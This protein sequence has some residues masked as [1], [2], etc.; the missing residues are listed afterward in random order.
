MPHIFSN[1]VTNFTPSVTKIGSFE[2][3]KSF[4]GRD[5]AIIY[6]VS[7]DD[8]DFTLL[9]RKKGNRF[10]LKYDKP[11]RPAST[12][13]LAKALQ[14]MHDLLGL[15]D[16]ETN[17]S[18]VHKPKNISNPKLLRPS[19]FLEN[20]RYLEDKNGELEIGFG[21]GRHLLAIAKE[22]P[23][24]IFFG[25]EIYKPAVEQILNR[26]AHESIDNIFVIDFDARL[27]L[28]T[29]PDCTLDKIHIH[30]PVP[31][32]DAKH[33]RVFVNKFVDEAFRVLKPKGT[34]ELRTDDDVYFEDALSL[35]LAHKAA[36]VHIYKNRD[37]LVSSKY[38]DRWKKHGKDIFDLKVVTPKDELN[39]KP[40]SNFDF[41]TPLELNKIKNLIKSPPEV[42]D[43]LILKFEELFVSDDSS[44]VFK[45]VLGSV[46]MPE[47]KYI[48]SDSTKTSF[49]PAKPLAI[50]D[51]IKAFNKLK[52]MVYGKG[53]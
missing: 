42:W 21:S 49:Y 40:M 31:W 34:L 19:F 18:A 36:D 20:D 26:M 32:N 39:Q 30:F 38:E 50:S 5:D 47:T 33:R 22:S 7:Q 53:D 13:L 46:D 8:I 23:D 16:V 35:V 9:L 43:G 37:I 28:Q 25:V 14:N 11:T 44:F 17:I 6:F 4:T 12:Q 3:K 52:E 29:L 24:K 45:I 10:L 48:Y 51:S 15:V 41:D 27:F 2:L 1:K